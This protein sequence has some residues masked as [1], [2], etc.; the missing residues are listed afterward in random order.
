MPDPHMLM[1][2]MQNGSVPFRKLFGSSSK[3]L[4]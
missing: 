1:I 4:T 2:G 3:C